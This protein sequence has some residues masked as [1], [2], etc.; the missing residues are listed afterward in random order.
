MSTYREIHPYRWRSVDSWGAFPKPLPAQ[1][2]EVGRLRSS[3]A[4]QSWCIEWFRKLCSFR[5]WLHWESN[6]FKSPEIGAVSLLCTETGVARCAYAVLANL[7]LSMC[8]QFALCPM[9]MEHEPYKSQQG[10]VLAMVARFQNEG[11]VQ[12]P[13]PRSLPLISRNTQELR[14]A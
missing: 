12:P 8:K 10:S 5:E 11:G 7:L 13:C 3:V 14:C 9:G 1:Q 2:L 4:R 6:V